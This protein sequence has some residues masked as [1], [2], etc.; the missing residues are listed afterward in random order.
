M[1]RITAL[2]Q[3][4]IVAFALL[5]TAAVAPVFAVEEAL[6]RAV[7]GDWLI[8][9][10]ATGQGC[11]V[12]LS[13]QKTSGGRVFALSAGCSLTDS[14][15]KQAAAWDF[16]DKGGVVFRRR[17]GSLVLSFVELPD[18]SFEETTRPAAKRLMLAAANEGQERL[19]T[20]KLIVGRWQFRRPGGMP[21]CTVTLT[22]EPAGRE[23]EDRALKF[24]PG[25]DARVM[26]LQLIKWH[27][28]AALLIMIGAETADLTLVPKADGRFIKAAKEG[29]LPLELVRAVGASTP[30]P[31]TAD[32]QG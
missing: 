7:T 12:A 15:L 31:A 18:G 21:I 8:A 22:D 29:G 20:P 30:P 17:D 13:S 16:N 6:Y 5:H 25:C 11:I 19:I 26:K 4:L 27:V 24:E 10:E 23:R 3:V 9:V 28:E 32:R 1:P 2:G 14:A